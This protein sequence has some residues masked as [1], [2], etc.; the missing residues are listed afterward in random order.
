MI[1]IFDIFISLFALL[2]LFP[3][4][5][6][7]FI[8]G[9]FDTGSPIFFQQRLGKDKKPF[10]LIKFRTMKTD[11]ASVASHLAA[12]DSITKLGL[13]LRKTKIDELPKLV[14]V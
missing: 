1:R 14:N 6:I 2:L 13:F 12:S 3:I 11:T 5:F 7:V 9:F 10:W 4:I 8:A